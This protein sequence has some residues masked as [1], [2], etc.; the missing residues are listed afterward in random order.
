MKP[1]HAVLAGLGAIAVVVLVAIGGWKLHWWMAKS[2][3]EHQYDINTNTQQWNAAKIDQL[4]NLA[5]DY[6]VAQDPGQKSAIGSQF[7]SI[8]QVVKPAP[9]ANATDDLYSA[10]ATICTGS[11]N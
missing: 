8:Y 11:V 10:H 5:H 9:P 4:R 3:V 6:G 2:T 7:C 1:F